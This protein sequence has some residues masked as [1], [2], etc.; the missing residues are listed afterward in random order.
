MPIPGDGHLIKDCSNAIDQNAIGTRK[1]AFKEGRK[2]NKK[3][4]KK[5]EG[6]KK[7]SASTKA[8]KNYWVINGKPMFYVE[9]TKC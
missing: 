3:D 6:K 1:K 2:G 7:W 9:R 5:G 4:G 8:E